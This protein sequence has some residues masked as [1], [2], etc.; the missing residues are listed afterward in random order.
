MWSVERQAREQM[1]AAEKLAEDW[2][3]AH[4]VR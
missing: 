4:P 2:L 3:K 1:L